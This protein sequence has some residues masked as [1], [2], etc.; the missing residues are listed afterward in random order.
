MLCNTLCLF[1]VILYSVAVHLTIFFCHFVLL[2][3]KCMPSLVILHHFMDNYGNSASFLRQFFV[4][5]G[6]LCSHLESLCAHISLLE[7]FGC[8]FM[9]LVFFKCLHCHFT[10]LYYN[11][12]SSYGNFLSLCA[13]ISYLFV[14]ILYLFV[15]IFWL[16]LIV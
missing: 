8:Y 10:V 7:W 15:V 9:Y 4:N 5:F 3:C 1:D 16:L 13:D 2:C 14:V 11:F 12:F 6:C